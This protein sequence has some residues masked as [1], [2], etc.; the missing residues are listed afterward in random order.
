MPTPPETTPRGTDE[1]SKPKEAAEESE[2]KAEA[3]AEAVPAACKA[4]G[5]GR[6]NLKGAFEKAAP[7]LQDIGKEKEKGKSIADVA[8]SLMD[9]KAEWEA[10]IAEA[11][12]EE[13]QKFEAY[14]A[15]KRSASA[16]ASSGFGS[17]MRISRS[18][19]SRR[20]SATS[21]PAESAS[22]KKMSKAIGA[23]KALGVFTPKFRFG[24]RRQH[25]TS[26]TA[27]LG[28]KLRLAE[29][30]RKLAADSAGGDG[31]DDR[32]NASLTTLIRAA[33]A[34][35]KVDTS[36]KAADTL[37][38]G[39]KR[40]SMVAQNLA[41]SAAAESLKRKQQAAADEAAYLRMLVREGRWSELRQHLKEEAIESKNAVKQKLK[42][43][44]AT[45]QEEHSIIG[46][47]Y[48]S[49]VGEGVNMGTSLSDAQMS[50]IFWNT[51]VLEMTMLIFTFPPA[52]PPGEAEESG[53]GFSPISI[54]INGAIVVVPCCIAAIVF[55]KVF[56]W[57]NKGRNNKLKKERK[58]A[59]V[60]KVGQPIIKA[61]GRKQGITGKKIRNKIQ[62]WTAWFIVFF[63]YVICLFVIMI[64]GA[65]QLGN[66]VMN[67]FLT[68]WG[69]AMVFTWF[70]VE[71]LEVVA[72]VFF[73][74]IFENKYVAT[75]YYYYKEYLM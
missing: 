8:R 3:E 12:T 74:W 72:L 73:P 22:D 27:E 61:H 75:F 62:F 51:L 23:S 7:K 44:W 48:P 53:G 59:A 45:A 37:A 42:D 49:D 46:A 56:I 17:L 65:T 34:E 33:Q 58:V 6:K 38:A 4:F 25:P 28:A 70:F 40:A 52:P 14:L 50:Q 30:R 13:Q 19:F 60:T 18:R 35:A 71:P 66:E 47:I 11:E 9:A 24:M 16:G 54:I 63:I 41:H 39:A 64:I 69:V 1:E 36:E 10:S 43:L 32:L 68:G 31:V 20:A 55:R 5:K 2:P 21:D 26:K 57:G 15:S 67:D 29:A